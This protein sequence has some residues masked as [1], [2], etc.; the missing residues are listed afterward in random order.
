MLTI[1]GVNIVLLTTEAADR[2]RVNH[3]SLVFIN[4][5]GWVEKDKAEFIFVTFFP[6]YQHQYD[7]FINF[8]F[9]NN[10]KVFELTEIQFEDYFHKKEEKPERITIYQDGKYRL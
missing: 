1:D 6:G 3:K 4:L 10:Q 5:F 9:N 2:K 8:T 7:Y